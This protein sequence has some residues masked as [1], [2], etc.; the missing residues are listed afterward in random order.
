MFI[1]NCLLLLTHC[2]LVRLHCIVGSMRGD[3]LSPIDDNKWRIFQILYMLLRGPVVNVKL[4]MLSKE[5][6]CCK[7]KIQPL[8]L[9][10]CWHSGFEWGCGIQEP[11]E[12]IS[13][14]Y[15]GLEARPSN[16]EKALF[17]THLPIVTIE[18]GWLIISMARSY[19]GWGF[20]RVMVGRS[21]GV[22]TIGHGV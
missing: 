14:Q 18:A 11:K 1:L 4:Y 12:T 8:K 5:V 3:F 9:R 21:Q 16:P 10:T 15:L 6:T 2:S 19:V 7:C 22:E 13:N 20:Y 17:A